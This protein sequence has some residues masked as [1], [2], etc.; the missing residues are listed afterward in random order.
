MWHVEVTV[1]SLLCP[2]ETGPTGCFC[3]ARCLHAHGLLDSWSIAGDKHGLGPE[4]EW[5]SPIGVI[6]CNAGAKLLEFLH[7]W[8]EEAVEVL[9][10]VRAWYDE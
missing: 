7:K 5:L 4:R 2:Y 6:G 3:I 10:L 1:W 9:V 8:I